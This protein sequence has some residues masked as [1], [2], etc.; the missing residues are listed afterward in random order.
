MLQRVRE[1]P[2]VTF[3]G[4]PGS[5][6]SATAQH[7]ALILQREGYEVIPV[8][9][10]RDLTQYRDPNNPQ[11]FVINDVVGVLGVNK[12]KLESF[13]EYEQKITKPFF[14]KTKVLL[15]CRET[16]FNQC[17]KSFFTKEQYVIKLHSS[18]NALG[19]D[20]Q[21]NI[22]GNHGLD[23]YLLSSAMLKETSRM[24]PLLCRLY[25]KE[26]KFK[27]NGE[28]FFIRPIK[29]IVG[30]FDQMQHINNLLY[31]VLVI[32]TLNN[33]TVSADIL[34]DEQN[35]YFQKMKQAVLE[36]CEVKSYTDSFEF[37]NA[38]S[39][40]EGTYTK[41]RGT[42]FTFVHDSMFEITAYHFGRQFP[43]IIL[44]YM[45]SSYIAN[46]VK[47]QRYREKPIKNCQ[48]IE[49][50]KSVSNTCTGQRTHNFRAI[51]NCYENADIGE[52]IEES[53]E[54][55]DVLNLC[56]R[57]PPRNYQMLAERLYSDIKDMEL[58][59]VFM[60]DALK[61][62]NLC[63]IFC[64]LL[65]KKSYTELKSVFLFT[66]SNV[67]KFD[68]RGKCSTAKEGTNK[69]KK[70]SIEKSIEELLVNKQDKEYI[71]TCSV[72]VISWVIFY[73]H[74]KIL[75]YI[76]NQ[77][78]LHRE[79]SP[80]LFG[81]FNEGHGS[82]SQTKSR[83]LPVRYNK[84]PLTNVSGSVKDSENSAKEQTRLLVLGCSGGDIETVR[85]LLKHVD[86][87]SSINNTP[88]LEHESKVL[89]GQV[90]PLT[91]ACLF[92]HESVVQELLG[93][94]ADVN[95][96]G[97]FHTPLTAACVRGHLSVVKELCKF[98]ANV[99]LES[100]YQTPL[101]AACIGGHIGIFKE[102]VNF[103]ANINPRR[104][105]STNS[106]AKELL[107]TNNK[108]IA[109]PQTMERN[110]DKTLSDKRDKHA[111][112]CSALANAKACISFALN[113]KWNPL[114]KSIGKIDKYKPPL[115]LACERGK[116]E[117]VRYLLNAKSDVNPNTLYNISLIAAC[118]KGH[119]SVVK[120]LLKK[121]ADVNCYGKHRGLST[122]FR[123]HVE[124]PL[125][126][127][128]EVIQTY[129]R[130]TPLTAA[131]RN[132]RKF[133]V[134][135]LLE[136]RANANLQNQEAE[137]PLYFAVNDNLKSIH[138]GILK[139]LLE[140]GADCTLC[141]KNDIRH[142]DVITDCKD[143]V[144]FTRKPVWDVKLVILE[145]VGADTNL[146]LKYEEYNSLVDRVGVS[147]LERTKRLF[148]EMKLR[149]GVCYYQN[150]MK[151]IKKNLRRYSI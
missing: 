34:K 36:R 73:G 70:Y 12:A 48:F 117:I 122:N 82:F 26:K 115:V 147:T 145:Q 93:V 97:P 135:K 43:E 66:K 106:S 25:S 4:V 46:N 45:R 96:A 98:G 137:T 133:V 41:R 111:D 104:F 58:Y 110:M 56:I 129:A 7:I 38:L 28:Q 121:K 64:D 2:Y 3:V 102:L 57:M 109:N 62:Q 49:K 29:C 84:N 78:E 11:V 124:K 120:E 13:L 146:R 23:R 90:T 81:Y 18:E 136:A 125:N 1:Q 5:G 55:D 123:G 150:V 72:R 148:H 74:H 35:I 85:I 140:N 100:K 87:R 126:E 39:A 79:T 59:E 127:K 22:L 107:C 24:F 6:K 31:A 83:V 86:K 114:Y 99:N 33:N 52:P 14:E 101:T 16:L 92:G 75:K 27:A 60:N 76:V 15:S 138:N 40:M 118:A 32:C 20:D 44:Q 10:F 134:K 30:E 88:H 61:D 65:E 51:S 132:Q 80:A 91:A 53:A 50:N 151:E 116:L 143:D 77:T 131:C 89:C 142:A 8:L 21:R 67:S 9:D 130:E 37:V 95:T 112:V 113:C 63:E 71:L 144:V 68:T 119:L 149:R 108:K 141:E 69:D 94:G 128:A 139:M 47:L 17:H 54:D 42:E 103:G 19:E 105:I